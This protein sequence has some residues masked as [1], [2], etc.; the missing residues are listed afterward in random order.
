MSMITAKV[1]YHPEINWHKFDALELADIKTMHEAMCVMEDE[2]TRRIQLDAILI[3]DK[4]MKQF[5]K[6]D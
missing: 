3:T 5:I 4:H 6:K 2:V 1:K